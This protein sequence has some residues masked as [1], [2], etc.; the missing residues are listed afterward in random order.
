MIR[1][2]KFAVVLLVFVLSNLAIGQEVDED[3]K[4]QHEQEM[5]LVEEILSDTNNL[6]LAENRALIY[7]VYSYEG[8]QNLNRVFVGRNVFVWS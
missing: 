4:K 8:K 7:L 6:R 5:E 3:L 1:F 2:C